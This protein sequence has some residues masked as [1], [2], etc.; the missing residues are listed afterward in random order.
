MKKEWDFFLDELL[1]HAATEFRSTKTY[2]LLEEKLEQ[3]ERDCDTMLTEDEKEFA[4]ECFELL[5]EA[6]GQQ[7]AYVYRRGLRDGITIL[8]HLGVLV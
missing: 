7:E 4:E 8:K 1:S 2:E 6:T 5:Y 3:M